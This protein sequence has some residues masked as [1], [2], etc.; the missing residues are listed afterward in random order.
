MC[1]RDR[2]YIIHRMKFFLYYFINF[3]THQKYIYQGVINVNYTGSEIVIKL[4]E[5]QGIKYISGIPGGF[6]L[7]LY[8]ALYKSKK[9]T[10]IL[11]RHEQGAGFIAQGISR[12]T[13]K[14]GV[15]FATS[16]PGVTNLL[17]AIADAKLDSIPLIAITGQV[18]LTAIGTD[19]FQEV[20]AYGL[21]IPITKHNFLVRN[22]FELLTIIPEAFKIASEGR[23]GPV[24]IDIPKNI[25]TAIIECDN[26]FLI[27]E[28]KQNTKISSDIALHST[29]KKKK[30][31]K[32]KK[33][34]PG[35]PLALLNIYRAARNPKKKKNRSPKYKKQKNAYNNT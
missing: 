25:Q 20:D 6:N 22:P 32:K 12:T 34:L 11:A 31:K 33:N 14:P 26:Y 19:A 4:L 8:D 5:N 1:I 10:H 3:Q 16:G 28:S 29:K 9:I 18:P 7:P 24:L 13:G 15:C 27:D 2:S 17:T 21:T 30:K 23:P 35:V